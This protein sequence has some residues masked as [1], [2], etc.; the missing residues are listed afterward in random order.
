VNGYSYFLTI[1]SWGSN[2]CKK[3][4]FAAI[5]MASFLDSSPYMLPKLKE[6]LLTCAPEERSFSRGF[7]L[8]PTEG[9]LSMP[10]RV[11]FSIQNVSHALPLVSFI[12]DAGRTGI[13]PSFTP[14]GVS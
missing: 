1:L 10:A 7:C 5:T 14:E 9:G 8:K 4:V 3:P 2:C 12:M 13:L 11:F 6:F